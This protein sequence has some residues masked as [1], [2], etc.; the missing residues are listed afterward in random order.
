MIVGIDG[1][2]LQG[3]PTGVGRYLRNLLREWSAAGH[4]HLIVYFNG[5]APDD[6]ALR[7]PGMESRPLGDSPLRGVLFAE[8]R[9]RRAAVRDAV[10]VF[11]APAYSCP[12][13]LRR[14][15]VTAIHDLSFFALPQEYTPHDG[16]R[17]RLLARASVRA[18]TRVLTISDFSR[19]EMLRLFPQ[20]AA[21]VVSIPL[22]PDDDLPQAP[23]REESRRALAV[24]GPLVLSVGAILN[25]RR[26]PE[27]LAAFALLR[28]RLP[29]ARLEVVGENRTHPRLDLEAEVARLG[30]TGHAQLRGFLDENGLALRYS[31]ADLCVVLSDYEGFGLPALEAL[32]RG[33]PLVTSNRPALSELFGEAALLVD[34]A[35]PAAIAEAAARVL[36]DPE[37]AARLRSQGLAVAA[38]FS[39]AETARRTWAVLEEAAG[40]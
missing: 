35:D 3:R 2:E 36:E 37:L 21:R 11:F 5:P 19:R 34:P 6:V 10:D 24:S 16:L 14:P 28:R 39:W 7:L 40:A 23:P 18:S 38:R 27:L 32:S 29:T 4:Q 8:T 20:A 15:R 31:A 26:L 22:G 30:L 13:T 17:R 9:L 25:R 1:R 33:V 12:L